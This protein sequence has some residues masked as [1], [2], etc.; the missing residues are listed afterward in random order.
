MEGLTGVDMTLNNPCFGSTNTTAQNGNW[1]DTATW[2]SGS[3]PTSTTDI[4]IKHQVTVNVNNAI[5]KSCVIED[6]GT[7]IMADASQLSFWTIINNGTF[8]AGTAAAP[9][10]CTLIVRNIAVDPTNDADQFWGGFVGINSSVTKMHGVV[11]NV[12]HMV[13]EANDTDTTVTVYKKTMAGVNLT[14]NGITV[15]TFTLPADLAADGEAPTLTGWAAGDRLFFPGLL[16]IEANS[17][18]TVTAIGAEWR[19]ISSISG[20]TITL[21]SGL[22]YDHHGMSSTGV[23]G[24]HLYPVIQNLTRSIV[25]KSESS[26]GVRGHVLFAD[27]STVDLRYASFLNLTRSRPAGEVASNVAGGVRGRYALHI[28]H[29]RGPTGGITGSDGGAAN[30]YAFYVYG[31]SVYNDATP[32]TVTWLTSIHDSSF[33]YFGYND[34]NW[35]FASGFVTE[36][37]NEAKNVIEYNRVMF[38]EGDGERTDAEGGDDF[39]NAGSC[40]W[41]RGP[42][43]YFRHNIAANAFNNLYVWGINFYSADNGN[44]NAVLHIPNS[45]GIDP[46]D[47]PSPS[48]VTDYHPNGLP[49]L[50]CDHNELFGC[51]NGFTYWWI[52][53]LNETPKINGACGTFK[54]QRVWGDFQGNWGMFPY[55]TKN[56]V[57]DGYCHLTDRPDLQPGITGTDYIS[58]NLTYQ[59]CYCDGDI[60]F[61]QHCGRTS[62]AAQTDGRMTITNCICRKTGG[63]TPFTTG[64]NEGLS[65]RHVFLTNVALFGA[66]PKLLLEDWGNSQ[67]DETVPDDVEIVNFNGTAGDD[68][69]VQRSGHPSPLPNPLADRATITGKL[70]ATPIRHRRG[71]MGRH[72]AAVKGR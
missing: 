51:V 44:T 36:E 5:C 67:G 52:G 8:R 50:E 14:L 23:S 28:H 53:T 26:S 70:F 42:Y 11:R 21:S 30:G 56:V 61:Q 1:N 41:L 19:T 25:V 17:A 59:N 6:V 43:N 55:D 71:V 62:G 2:T 4:R 7:L 9:I 45:V 29:L 32:G 69:T 38:G 10:S 39:G 64:G 16:R 68:F 31:C 33:G 22:T 35:Y 65:G 46:H 58:L 12:E 54:N 27:R 13:F 63:L 72:R 47:P 15:P 24:V 20:N 60:G 66:N 49:I 37:G 3:V 57:I 40:Y 48:D 18:T 34:L